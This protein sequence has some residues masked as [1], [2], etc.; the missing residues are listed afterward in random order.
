[1]NDILT[2][3]ADAIVPVLCLLIAAGGAYLVA[4]IHQQTAQ[5]EKEIDNETASKYMEMAAEAVVQAVTYT[6]QTFVDTLKS[7]GGFTKEKQ[8]E[9]YEKAKDKVLEILGDTIVAAL[10][11]IYG[12]FN[13]WLETKIEQTCRELKVTGTDATTTATT[14]ASVA[15]TIASTAVQQITAESS[16]TTVTE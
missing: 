11:E 15:A 3:L 12:D 13:A 9:A 2:Q 16:A 1:M 6:A 8:Q 14:A 7:S 10:G 5:I 4:L